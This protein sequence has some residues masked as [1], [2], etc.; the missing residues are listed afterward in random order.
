M[1]RDKYVYRYRKVE[2]SD[3]LMDI[4]W[5]H[6]NAITLVDNFHIVLIMDCTYKTYRYRMSL[7]EIIGVTSTEMT[8]CVGFAYLQFECADNFTWALQIVKEQITSGEVEVIVTD[9]DLAL[10]NAVENVF[11][12]VV[13]LLCLF[14]ICKNVKTKCKMNVF[15]KKKQVQILE[16]W[17]TLIYSY[18]EAQYYMKLAIFEGICSNCSIFYDYVHEQWLIPYNERFVEALT[19]RVM[20]FGNTTT[21]RV[22]S[23]HWSL[24][25]IL[26][27]SIGDICSVWETINSMIVLQHNEIIASFEKSIIQKVHRYSN[28][29]YAN[30][31]GVVSKNTIDHIAAE[32][33][34][35]KTTHG[36]PC[37][38][39]IATYS[40]IPRSIPLDVI[41][42][43]WSKL[44]F[45]VDASSKP[46]ELSVKHEIDVIVKKF[47]ELDVPGKISLKGKLREIAYPSTTSMFPPVAKVKTK[48]APKKGKSKISKRDKST[49]CDPSWWEYVDANV[50]YNIIDVGDDSNC[51]YRAVATLLGMGENCWAFI[52]QQCVVEL[53]EFMSHYEILFGGENYVRKLIHNVYVEQ[54]ASKDNWMTLPEMRYVIAL[55]FNLVVVA[56]SLNQSQTYFPLRSPPPTSMSD[57]RVI[58]IAFVN[59]CHFVHVLII[60]LNC[61]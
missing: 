8:F 61:Y 19:N 17:E 55:K 34:R 41:H 24:T 51:G 60:V 15:S 13:N 59:N 58:V 53:Q 56:L 49:K 54:V 16:A 57:Y 48:G 30:L 45:H 21:Q 18:D 20:H 43:W 26:Q 14:H 42:V 31:H 38:C 39:E 37:T 35:V 22:E 4:F 3:E 29:L 6:P 2:G 25:R 7:L 9:R 23:V 50:R 36:L 1:E 11:P 47:E 10:I 5:T 28:R 40:M 46:S 52:C 32:Y 27:D 12:K 33:N 44:T